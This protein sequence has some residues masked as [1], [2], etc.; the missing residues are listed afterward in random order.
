MRATKIVKKSL[1]VQD[2][3]YLRLTAARHITKRK[4]NRRPIIL[5][6]C[7]V[8]HFSLVCK[9]EHIGSVETYYW[10]V[11]LKQNYGQNGQSKSSI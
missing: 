2:L 4:F 9:Y 1:R 8:F 11:T 5:T 3:L 6:S 10:R 7:S